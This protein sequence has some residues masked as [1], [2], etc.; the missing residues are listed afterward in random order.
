VTQQPAPRS[1]WRWATAAGV[2]AVVAIAAGLWVYRNE[3]S[4]LAN[5]LA[6]AQFT[7]FTDFEGS[8]NDA[9]I[10]RDGRFVVFR[11][12]RDGP[13]DTWV[14]QV[15]SGHFL[16][17][18]HGTRQ[19]PLATVRSAG[20]VP[21]GSE[22]WFASAAIVGG[23]RMRLTP[24]IGGTPR[25]F[26]SEHAV[27]VAWSQD[28]S[29][30]VFHTSE[31][32][33]PMFVADSKGS[34]P[35]QIFA[36]KA[37]GHNH[38]PIWSPD[39]QWIY[40]LSGVWETME[41]NIWRIR[42]AGGTP[43][44]LTNQNAHMRYLAL[45]DKRTIVYT[46]LDQNGAGPWL[47]ALDLERKVSRRISSG[48][49]VYSSVDASADGRRLAVTVSH[50]TAN[51]WSFPIL[52]RPAEEMDVKPF[53]VPSVRAY[54]PRFGGASLFYLSSRGGGDG[55]WRH[56]N[57]QAT[58]IWRGTDGAIFEPPAVLASDSRGA[59]RV[60]VI[61]RKQ[62][63]RTLNTLAPDGSDVRPL[64]P[65]IDVTS[66]ASWSPD[67]KWIALGGVDGNGPGLFK[68]SLEGGEPQRLVDGRVANPVWSPDGSVIVY[69]GPVTG[70]SG[71]LLMVRP[72][73]T[74]AEAPAIR[75]GVGSERYRFVP[76]RQELVYVSTAS[77][78]AE[79][80]WLLDLVT[81][82]SRQLAN[83]DSRLTRTFDITSDGKQIVFDRMREN[84]DIVLIDL[85]AKP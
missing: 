4:A 38:Y 73:G 48:L 57:G 10:S 15:G 2:G 8:E 1:G 74:P 30:L 33:D 52:D 24:S 27:N 71:Y 50:P 23:D 19:T 69:T 3:S 31:P 32:G 39:A 82:K 11:S 18:T 61:L 59:P 20:F 49:E 28:G 25:P 72:D 13:E 40:F 42:P 51:L 54:A 41:M 26:L 78:A 70:P 83:F 77:P 81:K 5:P 7:R 14:S 56:E 58:E 84:S 67:G 64:A 9:A 65:A 36:L 37:G 22:I 55:L 85:P 45:L 53:S 60:A 21:D 17:L 68:I 66:A 34:N 75:V 43:E 80:F 79:N 16:N 46:S 44:R 29:Q 62:G 76:G 6:N 63:R 12:D 35:R 47:W